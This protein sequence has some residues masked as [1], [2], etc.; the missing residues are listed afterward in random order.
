MDR[1]YMGL[2]RSSDVSLR[3]A[4][5]QPSDLRSDLETM[6]ANVENLEFTSES[7]KAK[8]L[9]EKYVSENVCKTCGMRY[10]MSSSY[11]TYACRCHPGVVDCKSGRSEPTWTCCGRAS[12]SSTALEGCTRC[13][14][15]PDFLTAEYGSE[16]AVPVLK[17]PLGLVLIAIGK[18]YNG[19]LRF[20]ERYLRRG[21][22]DEELN[23]YAQNTENKPRLTLKFVTK[24]NYD[25]FI[26]QGPDAH[27]YSSYVLRR[28]YSHRVGPSKVASGETVYVN[29][30]ES[31][32]EFS[33][34]I[35]PLF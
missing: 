8:R 23:R 14:H 25:D 32:V 34:A 11:G 7:E 26:V 16:P 13:E 28:K 6:A 35:L 18:N 15:I 21:T 3:V 10:S 29:L 12:R 19:P 31:A 17:I 30:L 9:A 22:N 27:F 33:T 2:R 24:A 4:R 20:V 5:L 1:N